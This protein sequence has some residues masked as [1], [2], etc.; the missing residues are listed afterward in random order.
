MPEVSTGTVTRI[1]VADA[2]YAAMWSE[3]KAVRDSRE[4]TCS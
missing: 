1:R 3:M 2:Y 4:R